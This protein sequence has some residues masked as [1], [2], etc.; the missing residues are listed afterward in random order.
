[1]DAD[2]R[3]KLSQNEL[4]VSLVWLLLELLYSNL[5]HTFGHFGT[6]STIIQFVYIQ[7]SRIHVSVKLFQYQKPADLFQAIQ[8]H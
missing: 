3:R 7:F 4:F 8:E 5:A 1:M 6:V 2:C